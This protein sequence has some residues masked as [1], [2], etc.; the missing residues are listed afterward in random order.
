MSAARDVNLLAAGHLLIRTRKHD[1]VYFSPNN[2]L[3]NI[4]AEVNGAQGSGS[5]EYSCT[6]GDAFTFLAGAE[7]AAT[8]QSPIR[9]KGL[10]KY[11]QGGGVSDR[12]WLFISGRQYSV[13]NI[14]GE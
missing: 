6:L 3:L 8:F 4:C 14:P 13:L 5:G 7:L 10:L 9:S 2:E 11:H 1:A 12:F